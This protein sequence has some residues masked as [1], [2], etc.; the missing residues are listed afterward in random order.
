MRNACGIRTK[1]RYDG[2]I[3]MEHI[4]VINDGSESANIALKKTGKV[5]VASPDENP[6]KGMVL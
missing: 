5:K 4:D 6:S 3:S 2:R 1:E